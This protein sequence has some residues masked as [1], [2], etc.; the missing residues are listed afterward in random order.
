MIEFHTWWETIGIHA[1]WETIEQRVIHFGYPK[2]YLVSHNSESIR[3]MRSGDNFTTDISEWLHIANVNEA[4]RSSNKVNYIRQ[5]LRHND[6][7]TGLEYMEETLSYLAH[8]GWNDVDSAKIS[9]LL[10]AT[11]KRRSTRKAHLLRFETI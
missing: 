4:Y 7:C 10:S 1:L 3:R 2:M 9:N 11:D 6:R 8:E 5:M